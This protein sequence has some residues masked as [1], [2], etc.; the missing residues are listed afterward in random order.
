[1]NHV[2]VAEQLSGERA[3]DDDHER[4]EQ[5]ECQRALMPRFAAGDHRREEDPD[6]E[7][8]GRHEEEGELQVPGA[9]QVIGEPRRDVD[10]EEGGRLGVIVRVGAAAESLKQKQRDRDQKKPD[11]R[12]L[13]RLSAGSRWAGETRSR[14]PARRRRA[15]RGS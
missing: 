1:M 7:I 8:C 5:D 3:G 12:S 4:A 11:S 13:R 9:R 2:A 6:S 14:A 10:A 15:S